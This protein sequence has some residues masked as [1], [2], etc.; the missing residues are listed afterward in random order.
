MHTCRF[1]TTIERKKQFFSVATKNVHVDAY[2][3]MAVCDD[4]NFKS[5]QLRIGSVSFSKDPKGRREQ[6]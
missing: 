5:G 6:N 4:S 2:T 1:F 3:E